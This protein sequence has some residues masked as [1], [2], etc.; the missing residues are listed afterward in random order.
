MAVEVFI[1][2]QD[3]IF[4]N[5]QAQVLARTNQFMAANEVSIGPADIVGRA[6]AEIVSEKLLKLQIQMKIVPVGL[7]LNSEKGLPSKGASVHV[8]GFP[9]SN[10][11]IIQS[12][13]QLACLRSLFLDNILELCRLGHINGT[14]GQLGLGFFR[15]SCSCLSC[16]R[17]SWIVR[18][19]SRSLLFFSCLIWSS[20]CCRS[21]SLYLIGDW[22][23]L[24]AVLLVSCGLALS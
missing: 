21:Y 24:S 19:R 3:D 10:R 6:K 9:V 1:R 7:F 18:C 16:C 15:S 23:W 12:P 20:F 13:G 14:V 17:D 5:G 8:P 22:L 11:F 2:A 4:A